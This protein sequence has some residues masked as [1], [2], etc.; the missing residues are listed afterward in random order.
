M[1]VSGLVVTLSEAEPEALRALA[2]LSTDARLTVGER[3]GRRLALVAETSGVGEDRELWDDLHAIDGV[4]SVDVTF[5]AL[6]EP[7]DKQEA[8]DDRHR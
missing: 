5:V 7:G 3:F 8:T 6:D 1:S 4:E 2:R